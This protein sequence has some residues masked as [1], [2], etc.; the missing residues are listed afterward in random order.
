M[1]LTRR[2]LLAVGAAAKQEPAPGRCGW[3]RGGRCWRACGRVL[4][5]DGDEVALLD[6]VALGDGQLG[7]DPA[8]LGQDR[9]LHLHRLE[10]DQRVTVFYGVALGGYDLPD[11]G[12]HFRVDLA[13]VCL[14]RAWLPAG[15]ARRQRL[16]G[17]GPQA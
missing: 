14:L 9:D 10:D 11:V 13:H 16:S 6:D 8:A 12:D 4:L 17:C 15:K 2:M 7:E 5:D 1:R 3:A